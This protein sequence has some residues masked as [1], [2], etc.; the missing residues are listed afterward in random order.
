MMSLNITDDQAR[1]IRDCV[2]EM[3]LRRQHT[4]Q[5]IPERVRGLLA[6]VSTRGHETD[7]GAA[8]S[9]N[10]E[11]AHIS[12]TEAAHILGCTRRT[13]IRLAADLDGHKLGRDWIFNRHKVT[14]YAD[15]RKH[16]D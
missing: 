2:T 7:T 12:T 11:H 3:V 15:G 14:D 9:E 1:L 5:P 16:H 4:G 8:Q 13:V 10:E 6:Y